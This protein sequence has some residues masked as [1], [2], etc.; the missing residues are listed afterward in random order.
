MGASGA[1]RLKRVTLVVGAFTVLTGAILL[2]WFLHEWL[3]DE[4]EAVVIDRPVEVYAPETV[5]DGRVPNVIGLDADDARR[6]FSD[7][8]VE[9]SDVTTRTVPYVGPEGLVVSQEPASGE[10]IGQQEMILD[11]S[12]PARMPDLSGMSESE[13]RESLAAF[14]ARI[15][16]I[17]EY[18]EGAA[19]GSVLATEP[20][21]GAAI[22][23]RAVIHVAEPLSS[24]Y[25]TELPPVSS[26]CRTGEEA[27]VAGAEASEAIICRPVGGANPRSVTYVLGGEAESFQAELGLDDRG[28]PNVPVEFRVYVDGRQ[29]LAR[30]L[31]YG[32]SAPVDVSLAGGLQLRLETVAVGISPAGSPPLQAAFAEPRLAGSR[33]AIDEISEGLGG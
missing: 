3:G 31:S 17:G 8:G 23:D 21:A 14:G 7:A 30:R 2:G 27:I 26:G 20:S 1:N 25:L 5:V 10:P 4:D 29:R 18:E 12:Q 15:V 11:V 32:E 19:E 9:L 24:V 22:A 13:A 33:S 6:V 16:T 28:D